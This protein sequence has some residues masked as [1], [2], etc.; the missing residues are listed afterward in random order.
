MPMTYTRRVIIVQT[1][2]A[3]TL[4]LLPLWLKFS[5]APPPFTATY[6]LGFVAA[7]CIVGSVG[8]WLLLGAPNAR[9]LWR[10]SPR[11]LW[12]LS[13]LTFVGWAWL[14]QFWAYERAANAGVAQ[15]AA[16]TLAI[17]AA[18]A[19]VCACCPPPP[20]V[21]WGIAGAWLL[22]NS[23]I[24][25][26]QVALQGSIGLRTLGEFALDP[27]R[28]GVSVIAAEG[29]R[30][31]R[32]YGL[33]PHPNIFAGFL[34]VSLLVTLPA[35]RERAPLWHDA[36][37]GAG[38]WVLGLTFSRGA[39]LGFSAGLGLLLWASRARKRQVLRIFGLLLCLG[40]AFFAAYRP[41][42]LARGGIGQ[43]ATE[44]QSIAERAL[45]NHIASRAITAHPLQ[46]VGAG[47]FAWYAHR[48][49]RQ[50][51]TYRIRGK[52]VH[53]VPLLVTSELGIIGLCLFIAMMG[54]G[55]WSAW[56]VT[57]QTSHPAPHVGIAVV[58]AWGI[59]GMVDHYPYTLVM[60]LPLW[61]GALALASS[62]ELAQ[63]QAAQTHNLHP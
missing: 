38:V 44:Q 51:T 30:W 49:I 60:C 59:V 53:N 43:E 20:R 39:W 29:V 54:S 32:A 3:L 45:L 15:N 63:V 21:L 24:G 35:W 27:A 46:G 11:A 2:V 58:L 55:I 5:G 12:T 9:A 57:K 16:L 25:G 47:N 18:F 13:L 4:G 62:V 48:T 61:W 8:V 10:D 7:L 17:S 22:L 41:L 36:L 56:R 6:V 14:S 31:L 1:S 52:E 33:L 28:S 26:A 19:L 23:V 34:L 42:L 40:L 50:H 37:W